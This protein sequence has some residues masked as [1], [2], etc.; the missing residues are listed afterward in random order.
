MLAKSRVWRQNRRILS[1]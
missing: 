1:R